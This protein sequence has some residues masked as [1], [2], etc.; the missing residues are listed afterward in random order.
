VGIQSIT[1]FADGEMVIDA[2]D[3]QL[4]ISE[5]IAAFFSSFDPVLTVSKRI[6]CM[7]VKY[8]CMI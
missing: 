5:V 1:E 2:Y 6:M 4:V 7:R 8:R 3:L